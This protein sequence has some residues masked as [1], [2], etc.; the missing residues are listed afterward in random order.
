MTNTN[1]NTNTNTCKDYF[2]I[3]AW[4]HKGST[5]FEN[6]AMSKEDNFSIVLPTTSRMYEISLY[7]QGT[8]VFG[9]RAG[10]TTKKR[11]DCNG[12]DVTLSYV[13]SVLSI[14]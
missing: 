13:D 9:L 2:V 12:R 10:E 5:Y 3:F 4:E 1:T 8:G 6:F 7:H 11:C 14:V